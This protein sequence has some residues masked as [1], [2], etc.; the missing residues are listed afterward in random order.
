MGRLLD[1][2]RAFRS[3]LFGEN[4]S[5]IYHYKKLIRNDEK[6]LKYL[7]NI[8]EC[9][10]DDGKTNESL[11]FVN[12][13]LEIDSTNYLALITAA[14]YWY[15][16]DDFE[17]AYHYSVRALQNV[18]DP[19]AEVDDELKHKVN[20][21]SKLSSIDLGDRLAMI[22][23]NLHRARNEEIEWALAIKSRYADRYSMDDAV[24]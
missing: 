6:D 18:P 15:N 10:L 8:V 21:L 20:S 16:Y 17:K 7:V 9:Y 23:G 19:P 5:A 4:A 3:D 1:R 2:I 12:R 22:S 11:P 14:K 24:D 13:I